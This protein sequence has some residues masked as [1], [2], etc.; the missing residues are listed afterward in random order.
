MPILR[1]RRAARAAADWTRSQE[2]VIE[3]G[4]FL[5]RWLVKMGLV[6]GLLVVCLTVLKAGSLGFFI[7]L[8]AALMAQFA[9]PFVDGN[10]KRSDGGS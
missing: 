3:G 10:A 5:A 8:F 2:A 6:V 9:A 7:G 1:G 4:R